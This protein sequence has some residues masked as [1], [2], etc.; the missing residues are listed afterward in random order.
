M[1]PRT[2]LAPAQHRTRNPRTTVEV[3]HAAPRYEPSRDKHGESINGGFPLHGVAVLLFQSNH[4]RAQSNCSEDGQRDPEGLEEGAVQHVEF[5]GEGYAV[6][7]V[8]D[9][10]ELHEADD[11]QH[12]I[13]GKHVSSADVHPRPDRRTEEP[14]PQQAKDIEEPKES[15][16]AHETYYK[17]DTGEVVDGPLRLLLPGSAERVLSHQAFPQAGILLHGCCTT[18]FPVWWL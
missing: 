9:V 6:D 8:R 4:F 17:Q 14:Q 2:L 16:A 12:K 13:P 5:A 18:C 15:A 11:K 7:L 3:R 1:P 10:N